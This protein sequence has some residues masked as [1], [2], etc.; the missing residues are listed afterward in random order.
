MSYKN[1]VETTLTSVLAVCA[2]AVTV[3]LARR[4]FFAPDPNAPKPPVKVAAWESYNVG[5]KRIGPA[6]APVTIVEFSDFECPFCRDLSQTL[7]TLRAKYPQTLAVVYRNFPLQRIHSNARAAAIAAE[8]AAAR[9]RFAEYHDFL[10]QHQDS[11]G[12]IGW[13]D[14]AAR[15]GIQ[16]TTAF[17][18]CLSN[19]AAAARLRTDSLAAVTLKVAGT[20]TLMVNKWL[21]QG[22]LT[23]QSLDKLIVQ[24]LKLAKQE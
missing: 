21:V 11:L 15:T 10:F 2:V 4:E 13:T 18:A 8:C 14:V 23:E 12:K 16:D 1:F 5:D 3:M 6:R 9:G 17:A 19:S 22:A 20:P 7:L 24:E